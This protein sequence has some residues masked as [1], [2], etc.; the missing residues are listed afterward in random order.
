MNVETKRLFDVDFVGPSGHGGT[1]YAVMADDEA[2]AA[3][4]SPVMLCYGTPFTP[5]DFKVTAVRPCA[6][7]PRQTAPT[8][9]T[10]E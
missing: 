10:T 7:P 3:A 5:D 8:E 1:H 4:R 9:E 2:G 6:Q